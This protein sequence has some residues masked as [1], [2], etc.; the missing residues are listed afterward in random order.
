VVITSQT[1]STAVT[2]GDNCGRYRHC[3]T[4]LEPR[5]RLDCRLSRRR[6]RRMPNDRHIMTAV[7]AVAVTTPTVRHHRLRKSSAFT[8]LVCRGCCCGTVRKHPDVDHVG[9]LDRLGRAAEAGG[10]QL[11]TVD[12]LGDCSHSNVVVVRRRGQP[13]KW[14]GD[15]NT[16]AAI[17][18]LS[19]WIESGAIRHPPTDLA[20]IKRADVGHEAVLDSASLIVIATNGG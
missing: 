7:P 2:G 4:R 12:C 18:S 17:E 10:G 11:R 13:A 8:V 6:Y 14:I 1:W 15:L 5:R 19:S 3:Q 16:D 9:H 20:M